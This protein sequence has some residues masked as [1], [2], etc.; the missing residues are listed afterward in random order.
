MFIIPDT[1]KVVNERL[2][3]G[4]W[5]LHLVSVGFTLLKGFIIIGKVSV[6]ESGNPAVIVKCKYCLKFKDKS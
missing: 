3:N 2:I 4:Y 1:F 6:L 5:S